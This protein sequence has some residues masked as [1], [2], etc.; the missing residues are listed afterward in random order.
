[1]PRTQ[2]E[3]IDAFAAARSTSGIELLAA[4]LG[5]LLGV[6]QPRE[7]AAVGQRQPLEVEQ[8]GGGDE[9]PGERAAPGLVGAGDEAAAELA[10]EGEELARRVRAPAL[11]RAVPIAFGGQ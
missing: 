3:T 2:R 5:V 1:M 7:R 11:L 10:V 4:R 8:D 9:R 6:V